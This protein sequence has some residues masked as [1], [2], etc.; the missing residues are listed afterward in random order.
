MGEERFHALDHIRELFDV[1]MIRE[2]VVTGQDIRFVVD[3]KVEKMF[4]EWIKSPLN[5]G[6][7]R[8]L[9]SC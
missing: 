8:V 5:F 9:I 2:N 6:I 4:E 1:I 7:E 3:R